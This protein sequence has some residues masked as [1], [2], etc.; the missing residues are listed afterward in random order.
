MFVFYDMR[1]RYKEIY[2][3]ECD[4]S[5]ASH[6]VF[7]KKINDLNTLYYNTTMDMESYVLKSVVLND[8]NTI[9]LDYGQKYIGYLTEFNEKYNVL[10]LRLFSIFARKPIG[11][12]YGRK[13]SFIKW[14]KLKGEFNQ[15]C[16]V[17]DKLGNCYY[18]DEKL[19]EEYR[20]KDIPFVD[21]CDSYLTHDNKY[22]NGLFQDFYG[23]LIKNFNGSFV[24]L[25][26]NKFFKNLFGCCIISGNFYGAT[27]D[28]APIRE[29][30]LEKAFS[31]LKK[32]FELKL[33]RSF[34]CTDEINRVAATNFASIEKI[35]DNESVIRVFCFCCEDEEINQ[36]FVNKEIY[37]K[38]RIYIYDDKVYVCS[39]NID[40]WELDPDADF[41]FN[42][43]AVDDALEK[44]KLSYIKDIVLET[45]SYT[46]NFFKNS[47]IDNSYI[48]INI[49]SNDL[50]QRV[51]EK[52]QPK[53]IYPE[54]TS[55]MLQLILTNPVIESL[56]KSEYD[57]FK[58]AIIYD[59]NSR[60]KGRILENLFGRIYE[61]NNSFLKAI[62]V[63]AFML[64]IIDSEYLK[65][66]VFFKYDIIHAIASFK[67]IFNSNI[68]YFETM[69]KDM[70]VDMFDKFLEI[71][72]TYQDNNLNIAKHCLSYM[73]D[74]FG[75]HKILSYMD[76][77]IRIGKLCKK[78]EKD[79]IVMYRDYLKMCF[80]IKK[81]NQCPEFKPIYRFTKMEDIEKAHDDVVILYNSLSFKS[82]AN[83]YNKKFQEYKEVWEQFVYSN[84][85]FCI[86]YPINY[87]EIINEGIKL[88]HCV[89]SYIDA[90][91]EG[92][93]I[94]LFIRK[95]TD[96]EN[97][98]FTLEIKNQK[99][100]QC[101]GFGNSNI[102]TIKTLSKF[103]KEFCE[104][105][106]IEY[107]EGNKALCVN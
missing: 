101:H 29:D 82:K 2:N 100:R 37:E 30:V 53:V 57:G 18:S 33:F 21:M 31:Y 25:E 19:Y 69:N 93:T 8:K 5:K 50:K 58:Q 22:R 32:I 77:M 95:N 12:A 41:S 1:H 39:H 9:I 98:F 23:Y 56:M 97:P 81:D 54:V 83:Y 65:Q 3:S 80:D 11:G 89:K 79:Y 94:I 102:D 107:V 38:Y 106:N 15:Q 74:L 4:L 85:E 67:Y 75:N 73:V 70:F 45:F 64:Q 99:I 17:F 86:I 6:I 103:L 66:D 78:Y 59:L 62:G 60:G 28:L 63:P 16:I 90:V 36:P 88:H 72:N 40:N 68:S 105:K 13:Q 76:E 71:I 92:E 34:I 27:L 24:R 26:N 48:K 35:G 49:F 7:S 51:N 55:I 96:L 47:E 42:L 46:D 10:V 52:A 87:I 20:N 91:V 43:V 61:G 104:E 14:E 44:G 84:G